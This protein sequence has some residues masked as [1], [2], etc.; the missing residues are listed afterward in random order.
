MALSRD[1]RSGG[2]AVDPERLIGSVI[3]GGL[4]RRLPGRTKA[5]VGMGLLGVA[6]AAI[7]HFSQQGR[8][9][10]APPPPPGGR[11]LPPPPPPSMPPPPP[12]V[13]EPT[14]LERERE[15]ML[16]VEAMAAVAWA[17]GRLDENERARIAA[18][19][20]SAGLG[21][22][23]LEFVRRTL[24]HPPAAA[25]IAARVSDSEQAEQVYAASLLAVQVDTEAERAYLADLAARLRLAPETVTRLRR[26]LGVPPPPPV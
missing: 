19:A 13:P 12:G 14:P 6:I 11:P 25:E 24:E 5:A 7:E 1:D 26:L 17:D 18:R 9:G 3:F 8:G 16:L 10:A 15:A 23:E 2:G 21:A 20:E 4:G 22:E